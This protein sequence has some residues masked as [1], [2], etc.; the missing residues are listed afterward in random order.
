[1][2]IDNEMSIYKIADFISLGLNHMAN[3]PSRTEKIYKSPFDRILKKQ[4]IVEFE[5]LGY[6]ESLAIHP[7]WDDANSRFNPYQK[8]KLINMEMDMEV[9]IW[10]RKE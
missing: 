2:Y 4:D 6:E 1:M 3:K 7:H 10:N 9:T 5:L 8:A